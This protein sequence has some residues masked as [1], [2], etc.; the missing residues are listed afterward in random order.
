MKIQSDIKFVSVVYYGMFDKIKFD[1]LIVNILN[2]N[3]YSKSS[4]CNKTTSTRNFWN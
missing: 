4:C 3:W 1:S 2:E